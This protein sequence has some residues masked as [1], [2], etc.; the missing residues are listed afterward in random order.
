[1]ENA[2]AEHPAVAEAAVVSSPDPIR[3][4]VRKRT[5]RASCLCGRWESRCRGNFQAISTQDL[6]WREGAVGV[7]VHL[8]CV[9]TGGTVASCVTEN[10]ATAAD[11]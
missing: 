9:V 2:L 4:E 8:H 5:R 7:R 1:M 11:V 3:G 6:G 10:A